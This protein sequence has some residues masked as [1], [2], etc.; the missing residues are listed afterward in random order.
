MMSGKENKC[1][2]Y[3]CMILDYWY[4]NFLYFIIL[5]CLYFKIKLKII[6]VIRVSVFKLNWL[7][8]KRVCFFKIKVGWFWENFGLF[9]K[10]FFILIII[11]NYRSMCLMGIY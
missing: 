1:Y 6:Y 7:N 5:K 10:N 2:V 3:L 11:C 8:K 4:E 9:Y